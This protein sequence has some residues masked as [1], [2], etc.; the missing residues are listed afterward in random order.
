MTSST[1]NVALDGAGNLRITPQRDAAGN[2]TS[3]RI[4]TKRTDF[5]PPAAW[6][7]SGSRPAFRCRT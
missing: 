4:E 3:G 7:S 6:A 5:Q 1:S 2:W